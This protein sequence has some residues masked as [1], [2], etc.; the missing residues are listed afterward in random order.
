MSSR[1]PRISRPA[2]W[3]PASSSSTPTRG[4]AARDW[5]WRRR[6]RIEQGGTK[7]R[8]SKRDSGD[9]GCS[10][11]PCSPSPFPRSVA[12]GGVGGAALDEEVVVSG[13]GNADLRVHRRRVATGGRRLAARG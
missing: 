8:R 4:K 10:A 13:V 1:P 2:R 9:L 3:A 11:A 6:Q 5:W 7:Q 12:R